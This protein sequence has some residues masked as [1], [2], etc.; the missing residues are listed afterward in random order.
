MEA[1]IDEATT[2]HREVLEKRQE[3][4][5]RFDPNVAEAQRLQAF[6]CQ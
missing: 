3:R 2:R 6:F 1:L 4:V 5:V